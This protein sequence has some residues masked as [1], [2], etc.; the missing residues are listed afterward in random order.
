MY[1]THC[2]ARS[3]AHA[4]F[5]PAC[6]AQS[7]ASAPVPAYASAPAP[8]PA[9]GTPA[10]PHAHSAPAYAAPGYYPAQPYAPRFAGFWIRFVAALIDTVVGSVIMQVGLFALQLDLSAQNPETWVANLIFSTV[11]WWIYGAAFESS[12]F[13]ATPGK[14]ALGLRVTDERG[15]RISFGRATGRYLGQILSTLFLCI[16]YLMVAWDNRKQGLH[17]TI[18]GTLVVHGRD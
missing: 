7:T 1:C 8:A 14:L 2:G 5:C 6:G 9:W 13:Q 4:R 18:A 11:V 12:S 3:D 17:D 10:A 16:G 15:A